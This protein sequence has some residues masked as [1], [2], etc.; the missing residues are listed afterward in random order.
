MVDWKTKIDSTQNPKLYIPIHTPNP[1]P[2]TPFYFI[3]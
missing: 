2:L 1:Q 3:L